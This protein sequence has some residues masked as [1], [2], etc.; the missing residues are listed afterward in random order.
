MKYKCNKCNKEFK[1]KWHYDVHINR[2]YSCVVI[3]DTKNINLNIT[4]NYTELHPTYTEI[5]PNYTQLTRNYT[6]ISD[7]NNNITIVN[8]CCDYCG[9][10]FTRK[11]SLDRHLIKSCKKK[12]VEPNDIKPIIDVLSKL[13]EENKIIKEEF[14]ELKQQQQQQEKQQEEKQLGV[15]SKAKNSKISKISNSHNINTNTNN[16]TSPLTETN[17]GAIINNT[18]NGAITN[19]TNNTNNIIINGSVN[20]AKNEVLGR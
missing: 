16:T 17:N 15:V 8:I 19:N 6:Q 13:K 5:T 3:N 10:C 7:H 1:Q 4:P 11:Q 18:N 2:K 12:L 9:I 20:F 14:I